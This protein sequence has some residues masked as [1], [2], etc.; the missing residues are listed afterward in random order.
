MND[1]IEHIGHLQFTPE[2]ARAVLEFTSYDRHNGL[3][4]FVNG[5]IIG[6]DGFVGSRRD[7]NAV[8]TTRKPY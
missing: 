4:L 6:A 1:L 8:M 3:V 2:H 5:K 7:R